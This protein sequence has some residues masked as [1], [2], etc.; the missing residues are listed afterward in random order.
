[1]DVREDGDLLHIEKLERARI[2][3]GAK[4]V[5]EM[6]FKATA[7]VVDQLPEHIEREWPTADAVINA[8]CIKSDALI[9][10]LSQ[11]VLWGNFQRGWLLHLPVRMLFSGQERISRRGNRISLNVLST[12]H[13]VSPA[14]MERMVEARVDENPGPVIFAL[15]WW[16][17][18]LKGCLSPDKATEG[19]NGLPELS[20]RQLRDKWDEQFEIR[21]SRTLPSASTRTSST[22]CSGCQRWKRSIAVSTASTSGSAPMNLKDQSAADARKRMILMSCARV[23]FGAPQTN[24]CTSMPPWS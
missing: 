11:E 6:G 12:L 5:H 21:R 7:V 16:A 18:H 17:D 3:T 1:M 19:L 23:H 14:V 24:T 15:T 4:L 8:S 2:D 9:Y 20:K 22:S 10:G 13:T